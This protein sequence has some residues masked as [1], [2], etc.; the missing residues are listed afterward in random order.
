MARFVHG[1]AGWSYRDWVGPFY[2]SGTRSA[3]MLEH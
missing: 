3:D 1:T 2:P